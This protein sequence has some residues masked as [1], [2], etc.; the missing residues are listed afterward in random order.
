MAAGNPI[1]RPC[2]LYNGPR[3]NLDPPPMFYRHR[4]P[5]ENYTHHPGRLSPIRLGSP[6]SVYKPCEFLIDKSDFMV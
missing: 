6:R 4:S 3:A 2:Y 5:T 1:G